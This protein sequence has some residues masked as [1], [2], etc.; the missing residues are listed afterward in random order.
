MLIFFFCTGIA[1]KQF[2]RDSVTCSEGVRGEANANLVF[3]NYI[4]E[5]RQ[6]YSGS[7]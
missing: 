4:H 2:I 5:E 1:S 6:N 3:K 7:Y